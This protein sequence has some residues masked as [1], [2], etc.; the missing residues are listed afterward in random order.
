[1]SKIAASRHAARVPGQGVR[2]EEVQ[3]PIVSEKESRGARRKRETRQ[4][5]LQ[6]AFQLMAERGRDA[7]AIN[8]ITETADVGFGSF[9]QHFESKE[10]IYAVLIDEFFEQFGDA[11]DLLTQ[12]IEDPAEVIAA[13][14]RHTI[15]RAQREPLWGRFLVREGLSALVMWRGL[16]V[17]LLRDIRRGIAAG[18]FTAPDPLMAFIAVGASVLGAICADQEVGAE[19]TALLEAMGLQLSEV[20]ERAAATLLHT[21]GVPYAEALAIAQRPLPAFA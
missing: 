2:D 11:L 10:A 13:C 20:P 12:D 1:M 19:Q 7:V 3:A 6:A 8:E 5:L 15:L 17:R 21:L 16:G 9:Y 4:R 18:R 14:I